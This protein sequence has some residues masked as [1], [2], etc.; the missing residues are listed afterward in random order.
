MS[1]TGKLWRGLRYWNTRNQDMQL[2]AD[3][4]GHPTKMDDVNYYQE[5]VKGKNMVKVNQAL[6][7]LW[8]LSKQPN[9]RNSSKFKE[10]K[11]LLSNWPVEE[12][13]ETKSKKEK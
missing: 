3:I 8:V 4:T 13:K 12:I 9:G 10:L 6:A 1:H 2:P 7:D 11:D 5:F